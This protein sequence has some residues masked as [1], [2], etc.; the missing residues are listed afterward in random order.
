MKT[1]RTLPP[2]DIRALMSSSLANPEDIPRS[3][4]NAKAK[5]KISLHEL[6]Y[7][8]SQHDNIKSRNRGAL[9]DRGANGGLA[10]N[11]V[12]VISKTDR[13]VDVSGLDNHEMTNLHI[14]TAGG[15]ITTQ[16]GEAILIMHQYAHIPN[17][18]TIHSC[19][20]VEQ[21]GNNVDDRSIKLSKGKQ[22]I[23]TLDGY[24]IP[25]N[26]INGLPYMSIRPFSDREF[27]TL[28]HIV[29]TSDVPWD[30]TIA[31][32]LYAEEDNW[33]NQIPDDFE[34][35]DFS[36]FDLAGPTRGN[37]IAVESNWH[38]THGH[39]LGTLLSP[40]IDVNARVSVPTPRTFEKYRDFFLRAPNEVIS[41]TFDATTQ[42]AQSGWITGSIYDTYRS[43]FPALNVRRRNESVATDTIFCDVSAI[44]DGSTC[45]QF[46]TGLQSKFCEVYG[47][48]TDGQFKQ[49]LLDSIRKNGAMDTLISDRAQAEISNKV[50]DVLRQLRIDSWQ[51]EPHYQHQNQAER[52]YKS[53]KHNVNK[54]MNMTAAPAYCWLLCLQYVCFIMNRLALQSIHWRTPY[55]KLNGSTPDISMIYRFKFYDRVYFKRDESRG[56]ESFPSKSNETAGR[57]VG[58]SEDV[59]HTMTYKVLTEDTMKVLHRSRIKL[60]SVDP[61]LRLDNPTPPSE[62]NAT[63]DTTPASTGQPVVTTDTL[64]ESMRPLA[65]FTTDD[66]IGR[67]YLSQPEEDGTR[68]RI[69]IIE[70]LDDVDG[71]L[72]NDPNMI[73][74]RAN[75]DDGTIEEIITYNQIIDKLEA[76]DGEEDE[77]HFRSILNHKGPLKPNHDEYKGS[78]WNLQILWENDEVTWEPLR[79]IAASDPVS[80]AIYAKNNQLL[81]LDGWIRFKRLAS[82]QKKLLRMTHQAR[83]QSY[84]LAPKYK[85]GVQVPRNHE[86]AQ[87]IDTANKNKLWEE[88][89]KL[90]LDQIN[91]YETF[92]DVGKRNRP[93]GYRQIRVHFTYDVKPTLKRKA[94]LVADGQLTQTPIDSVY[95]SV[96][97]IRG[98]KTCIFIAELNRLH[99]WSSDVGNAY[100]EAYTEEKVFIV[101]GREFGP[102]HGHTLIISR[103]LY[104]LKSSGLRWWERFSDILQDMG[105][106]PSKAEDDIWMRDKGDHYE[107]IAR[108]VDDLAIVSKDPQTIVDTLSERYQLKLKGSGPIKYHLGSDFHRDE[109]GILCMSPSKYIIRMIDNY[110]RMFGSKP[111]TTYSSPLEKGDH[112]EL[113]TSKEL[114]DD[115]IKKYQSLIGALQW[116]ITLGRLDI[117]TAVMTMSSFRFAPRQGHL[118]RLKRIYG[119]L[120][121]MR[122]GAV[123]FRTGSPDFSAIPLTEYDWERSIYGK[124][125]EMVP[126]DAPTPYGPRV[127]ITTYVDANLCHDMITGR[128]V[129]GVLHL[130]NQSIIDYYTKKQPRVETATY[131]SE[132]MAARTATEQ[133]MDLRTALRYLGVNISGPTYMFGDNSTVVNS[134]STPKARLHKR[135]VI[136]SFHRV[137]EAIASKILYFIFIPGPDN[138]ADILSK[139]WGFQQICT[140]LKALLFWHGD[141]KDIE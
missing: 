36:S 27:E 92:V 105:F 25:L 39:L 67:S 26:M 24:A 121:K 50:N 124:V 87:S 19:I 83:L 76:E 69:K 41:K 23:T 18:K 35:Y 11:D 64:D 3:T 129:T 14:V 112:P 136:L 89:E 103:A 5:S 77:W 8:V 113:D 6:R 119:Y 109:N 58:F 96:V 85:F 30:P 47:M 44:D 40:A 120:S 110:E 140:Q 125:S 104:G 45:A 21:F 71:I 123:R 106:F 88:A 63:T 13:L 86:Q 38:E 115:S 134:S 73:K 114:D 126:D 137:R 55:E 82:R 29:L 97:S 12:R 128:S 127:T 59:G 17:G 68:R 10:G 4:I 107:Y 122:H 48:K 66:L 2:A 20:Q 98:P 9:V 32:H 61:N 42:Y 80:C 135:H 70:Q 33:D 131:G 56:G 132:Y 117:A 90:E 74:F 1:S 72:A 31:D 51:S 65:N 141:T 95:S 57:F 91:E 28:P 16:H 102:L 118:D 53:V 60:A 84:R 7:T 49:T 37:S 46:F 52:R 15:V 79:I 81:H 133:I 54:V 130:L 62:Q 139:H 101:A 43:P 116:V 78:S 111:K 94:R 22:L 34:D 75:T 99:T 100:L 108:Y 93:T 138:P